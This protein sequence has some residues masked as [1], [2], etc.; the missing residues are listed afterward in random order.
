M[1]VTIPLI[2][3]SCGESGTESSTVLR[4]S[5]FMEPDHPHETCGYSAMKEH[6][7]GS[8]LDLETYPSGQIGSEA[9][10]LEQVHTDNLE[11]ATSGPAFLGIYHEPFNAMDVGYMYED[12]E[13]YIE[14]QDSSKMEEM[15]DDLYVESGLK[16]F[17]GWYYGTRHITAN[18]PIEAPEDLRGLTL[19]VTQAP[20]YQD[21]MR[22]MGANPEPLVLDEL[23]LALQ[24]GVVDAQ[25]NPAPIINT[26]NF[27]EVQ[28]YLVLSGHMVQGL[29]I[30]VSS[31]IWE[32]LSA[33]EQSLLEEAISIGGEAANEC[34]LSSEQEYLE[35]YQVSDELDV[36]DIDTTDFE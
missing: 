14:F 28:D 32:S 18:E 1:G 10:A 2:G 11:M 34:V 3:A 36:L 27:H 20:L 24:Q 7:E 19:R 23:Y 8:N 30:S 13:Q 26:M 4:I 5:H 6:L 35:D 15:L 31:D 12:A 25:E 33:D 9:Q 21:L 29:H 17:P 16:V 22:A